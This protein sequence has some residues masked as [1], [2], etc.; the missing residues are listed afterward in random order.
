LINLFLQRFGARVLFG[1]ANGNPAPVVC[2][3]GALLS[4]LRAPLRPRTGRSLL[5]NSLIL[6]QEKILRKKIKKVLTLLSK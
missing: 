1:F 5:R 3:T 2:C 6:M 4:V